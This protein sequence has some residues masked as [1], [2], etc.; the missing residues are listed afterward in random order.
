MILRCYVVRA[1]TIVRVH[2]SASAAA[3]EF[4]VFL[5]QQPVCHSSI[6]L[7]LMFCTHVKLTEREFSASSEL[8]LIT[9]FMAMPQSLDIVNLRSWATNR[10]ADLYLLLATQ[11]I[12]HSDSHLGDSLPG[13]VAVASS[14][15]F[16]S[17]VLF[18]YCCVGETSAKPY[19]IDLDELV[20]L[21]PNL[22]DSL[23][24]DSMSW[25]HSGGGL[26]LPENFMI[27]YKNL[28]DKLALEAVSA[29]RFRK[30]KRR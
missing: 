29:A 30:R 25:A 8:S 12:V 20:K 17:E 19:S 11:R 7:L 16:V 14:D 6:G 24:D 3:D 13:G 1:A 2:S 5:S 10:A 22:F 23:T 28:W 15:Q 4:R 21:D 9:K 27:H 18:R 26:I